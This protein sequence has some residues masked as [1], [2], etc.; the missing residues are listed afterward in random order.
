MPFTKKTKTDSYFS[1]YQTKYR[2]RREGKTDYFARQKLVT[3]SKNKYGSP[4]YRLVVRITNRKI[5]T[6]IVSST[7]K[8]DIVMAA[9]YS[10]ELPRYGIKHGLSNWS[11]AYATG[12]LIARRS[13]QTLG[14]ADKYIGVE[15]PDG[16]YSLTE[17][18]GDG[19]RPFKVF[20]DVGLHRTSTGARI[21]G[22]LKG[23]SDGGL[24]VP[25][26]EKRFPGFDVE[27]KELDAEVLRKYI[28]GGHVS[29]YME[30]LMD[31]DEERYKEQFA[32]YIADSVEADD[33]EEIYTQAHA[34]I[35]EDPSFK[36]SEK[37]D[38]AIYKEETKKHKQHKITKEDRAKRVQEKIKQLKQ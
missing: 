23:A 31:D 12:L 38:V 7:I 11:A 20:L 33:L 18:T 5:I 29:E 14:L 1:R 30:T 34:K 13:L 9:A 2:R 27:S 22:V 35:R 19:P 3:Q 21:F 4:K 17:S 36:P 15:E 28:F 8:G 25:H 32:S 16:S 37:Q 6:Q 24:Y 26:S 10:S